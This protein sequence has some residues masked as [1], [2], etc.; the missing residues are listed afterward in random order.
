[1]YLFFFPSF[2]GMT[3]LSCRLAGPACTGLYRTLPH[4]FEIVM[5]SLS[6]G[7]ER[8]MEFYINFCGHD[9]A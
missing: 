4:W 5:L 6:L 2:G 8:V 1:M 3:T 7:G 9:V